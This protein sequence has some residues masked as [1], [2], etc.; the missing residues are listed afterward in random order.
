MDSDLDSLWRTL[1]GGA[2]VAAALTL[3]RL[4]VEQAFK[5]RDRRLDQA[6]RRGSF[7][8]DAEARLERLLQDRLS[9]VDRRL[10]RSQEELEDERERRAHAE[11]AYAVLRARY[12]VLSAQH[13]LLVNR[14][15]AAQGVA[16]GE[17]PR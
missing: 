11:R 2:L 12:A 9:E 14:A 16:R 3:A 5:H 6:D 4:L 10:E 13:R 15:S 1:G 7:E 8:R 17:L